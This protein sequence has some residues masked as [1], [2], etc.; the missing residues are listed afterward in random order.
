MG[1]GKPLIASGHSLG[2]ALIQFLAVHPLAQ[3]FPLRKMYAFSAPRVGNEAFAKAL[4]AARER[5]PDKE[6]WNGIYRKDPIPHL[7]PQKMG[8]LSGL[9]EA[10]YEHAES[11]PLLC[12]AED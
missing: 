1:A 5:S 6:W 3:K 7:P 4:A 2:G 9:P 12:K 10:F 11:P 8:F